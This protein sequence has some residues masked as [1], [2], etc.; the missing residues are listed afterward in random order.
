MIARV[1]HAGFLVL[2]LLIACLLLPRVGAG[3]PG[4]EPAPTGTVKLAP[5][6]QLGGGA[7]AVA[8]ADGH[9]YLSVGRRLQ[10]FALSE[11]RTPRPE[12]VFTT[13]GDVLGVAVAGGYAYAVEES[14]LLHVLDV[15]VPAQPRPVASLAG[16]GVGELVVDGST[17]F[18]GT[19]G[20]LAAIDVTAP[21]APTAIGRVLIGD[22]ASIRQM[23]VADGVAYLAA[24]GAGLVTVDVADPRRM[25]V[26]GRLTAGGDARVVAV[27][28]AGS[29]VYLAEYV[30]EEFPPLIAGSPSGPRA[31]AASAPC[32][33]IVVDARDPAAPR[34]IHRQV[35]SGN[36][37]GPLLL[38]GDRLY[39]LSGFVGGPDMAYGGR[40]SL[41]VFDLAAPDAP[42]E[43]RTLSQDPSADLAAEGNVLYEAGYWGGLRTLDVGSPDGPRTLGSWRAPIG[44]RSVVAAGNTVFLGDHVLGGL[45]AVDA[46]VP[47][48]PMPLRFQPGPRDLFCGADCALAVSKGIVYAADSNAGLV[49]FDARPPSSLHSIAT[50]NLRGNGNWMDIAV[51]DE[52]VAFLVVDEGDV[53]GRPHGGIFVLDVT[54]PRMPIPVAHVAGFRPFR[55]TLGEAHHVLSVDLRGTLWIVDATDPA[56]PTTV[57]QLPLH[58][59]TGDLAARDGYA[60]V[61][62]P[63]A[64][65]SVVDIRDPARPRRV[66]H[67]VPPGGASGEPGVTLLGTLA[68][69]NG[70]WLVDVAQPDRPVVV[71]TKTDSSDWVD[72]WPIA[73]QA[74]GDGVFLLADETRGLLINR[75]IPRLL[76]IQAFLPWGGR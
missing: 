20:W 10:V 39:L 23:A 1:R 32:S 59:G 30:P 71:G 69:V 54:E 65:L 67:V 38:H 73:G 14:G 21:R 27:A 42:T 74:A 28:V 63:N 61:S 60:Y 76:P 44:P 40:G 49:V 17:L 22:D 50:L 5:V 37:V 45:W 56:Q 11:W 47:E 43:V 2:P 12:G 46:S 13:A 16:V 55:V 29:L 62:G 64:E 31:V 8:A 53:S 34:E 15:S 41:V 6:G 4:A 7:Y 68:L 33:L 66:G 25:R 9:A 58:D 72:G 3:A 18:V 19:G 51:S 24:G 52:D 57:A 35:V 26:L 70:H 75:P 36:D 48:A